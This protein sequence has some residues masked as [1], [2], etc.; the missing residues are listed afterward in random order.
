MKVLLIGDFSNYHRAL[1]DGLSR[2][3]HDVTVASS[4]TQWLDT[5]RDIDLRRSSGKL[6]GALLYAR[7]RTTLLHRLSGYDV[8]QVCSPLFVDLRPARVSRIFDQL[9]R[10]NGKI[11][12]T[13][14]STDSHL[15]ER[16]SGPN[17]PL[18]YS[19]WQVGGR[20]SVFAQSEVNM[21]DGWL[22]PAMRAHDRHIY[23][24]VDGAVTALYEY[25]RIIE[26]V[27]PAGR[28]AYGGIPVDL[29]KIQPCP[30]PPLGS[31]NPV[32]IM[33][34]YP[35]ARMIEKGAEQ[36]LAIS[37]E[38]ERRHPGRIVVDEVTQLPYR[39]FVERIK[40]SHIVVDQLYSYTPGTTALLAM[41]MGRVTLSGGEEE[42][43][44]FIGERDLRPII[45]TDPADLAAT[46]KR[47]EEVALDP[48]RLMSLA[49]D[50][51]E[52]VRRHNDSLTVARRFEEFWT[53]G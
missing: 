24:N 53:R 30:M 43:Y 21:R 46:M 14:L 37:R 42:Y 41:A 40:Q 20:P 11:Y 26:D 17:S 3:G 29:R 10:R 18:R 33:V 27:I 35:R 23:E 16:L 39:E 48:D 15:V 2:L 8:V 19:E 49:S 52:F 25:H 38:L 6:G 7:L 32:R 44:D 9:K 28:L 51:P 31:G 47:L 50:G 1:G 5:E 45:N 34:A 12:L 36:L 22:A 13:A 4:G